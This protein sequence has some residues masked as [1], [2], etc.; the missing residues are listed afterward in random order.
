[1]QQMI[2]KKKMKVLDLMVLDIHNLHS[3]KMFIFWKSLIKKVNFEAINILFTTLCSCSKIHT[4]DKF[5]VDFYN[6]NGK[7]I[8]ILRVTLL[9]IFVAVKISE[10]N[11]IRINFQ[12]SFF[13]F[14][15]PLVS[16]KYFKQ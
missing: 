3:H 5:E 11:Q 15:L 14:L 12:D 13:P 9:L 7:V 16:I 4:F 6:F 8:S 1:M 10:S 2:L